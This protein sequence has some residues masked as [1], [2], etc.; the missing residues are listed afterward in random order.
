VVPTKQSIYSI[1]KLTL[2]KGNKKLVEILDDSWITLVFLDTDSAYPPLGPRLGSIFH[3][4]AVGMPTKLAFIVQLSP[5]V[6]FY[7]Y[8]NKET[9]NLTPAFAVI[10]FACHPLSF[11]PGE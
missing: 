5:S 2:L 1:Y 4:R 9:L 8:L 11:R 6:M 3:W 10:L 7:I